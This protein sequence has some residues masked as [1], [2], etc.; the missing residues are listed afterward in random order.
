LRDLID[1][2]C[3]NQRLDEICSDVREL[4]A[5]RRAMVSR[6]MDLGD[7]NF[8]LHGCW[9]ALEKFPLWC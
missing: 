6:W 1:H 8:R 7:V 2:F 9:R 3:F 4:S 5:M